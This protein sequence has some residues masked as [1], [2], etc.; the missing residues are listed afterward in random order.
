MIDRRLKLWGCLALALAA[1]PAR[2]QRA[3]PSGG[4]AGGEDLRA[5]LYR[6]AT[7]A[8]ASGQWA[9]ARDRLRAAITIRHSHPKTGVRVF[10]RRA[11]GPGSETTVKPR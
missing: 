10:D 8:A 9:E 3:A 2:A 5:A 6:E 4:A 11:P 7:E 1:T